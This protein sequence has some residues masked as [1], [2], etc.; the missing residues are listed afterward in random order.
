M[1]TRRRL[2]RTA[3]VACAALTEVQRSAAIAAGAGPIEIRAAG[4]TL[5]HIGAQRVTIMMGKRAALI[6]LRTLAGH[7]HV[8]GL[9]PLAGMTGEVTIADGRPSLA[10]VGADGAVHVTESFDG[11]A[12]F[13]V[14][15]E[16]AGW[17]TIPLP[18]QVR[19]YGDLQTLVGEAGSRLGLAQAFPF[20]LSGR[21]ELIDFHVLDAKPD[22]PTGMAAHQK[23]QIP[24]EVHRQDA[25]LV[26]FWSKD[27]QGIFTPM[28]SNMHVHFQ[29]PDRARSWPRRPIQ[30]K[31]RSAPQKR[32]C[33]CSVP[34]PCPLAP[35][36]PGGLRDL[37]FSAA[38]RQTRGRARG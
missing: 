27:H 38:R 14:W 1:M 33:D 37:T 18:S 19:T 17:Q 5:R 9:G 8:N 23:I 26:G 16:I 28:G 21:L 31:C 11:G 7:P 10:R 32:A 4:Y 22:T 20:E 30:E 3:C 29:N 24:F 12:P 34:S 6:D 36:W 13:F 35:Q 15:A 25:I 2:I